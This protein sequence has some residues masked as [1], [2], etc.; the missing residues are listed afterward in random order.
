MTYQVNVIAEE[1]SKLDATN[2]SAEDAIANYILS[3]LRGY[4]QNANGRH[5]DHD[6]VKTAIQAYAKILQDNGV[7]VA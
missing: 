7:K 2:Y 3:R 1:M 6:F 4:K 5:L